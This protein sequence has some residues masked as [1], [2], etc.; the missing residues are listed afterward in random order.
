[1]NYLRHG[2]LLCPDDKTIQKELLTEAK[3]Y[4]VR[5]VIAEL[6]EKTHPFKSSVIIKNENHRLAVLSWLP[7]GA[8]CSLLYQ[9]GTGRRKSSKSFHKCCDNSNYCCDKK[10]RIHLRRLHHEIMGV[11]YVFRVTNIDLLQV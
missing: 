9:Y 4:Q 5:G 11:K 6:E 10:W 2:E 1:M 8:R 7:S 3:F